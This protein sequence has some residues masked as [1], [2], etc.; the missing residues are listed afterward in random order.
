MFVTDGRVWKA[1]LFDFKKVVQRQNDGKIARIYTAGMR[2][3]F[4]DEWIH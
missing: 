1:R 3:Q 2:N 4:A